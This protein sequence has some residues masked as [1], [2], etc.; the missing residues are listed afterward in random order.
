MRIDCI[1]VYEYIH[2]HI[3][4]FR[5]Y[6]LLNASTATNLVQ[7]TVTLLRSLQQPPYSCPILALLKSI[8]HVESRACPQ[9]IIQIIFPSSKLSD[10]SS[11]L[12][13]QSLCH[14]L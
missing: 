9:N 10:V 8:I 11:Y 13:I 7:L 4:I 14:G 12:R 1:C 6:P 3:C 2:T 5:I